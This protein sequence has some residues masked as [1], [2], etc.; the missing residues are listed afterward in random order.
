MSGWPYKVALITGA[1]SGLGEGIALA[2][3]RA[4]VK[5]GLLARRLDKLKDLVAKIETFGGQAIAIKCDVTISTEVK[6]A[7]STLVAAFG[8]VDLLIANAG[9][10]KVM[11]ADRFDLKDFEQT[12]QVNLFGAI[13]AVHAV[14]P[15]MIKNRRGHIVAIS[16]LASFRGYPK[17]FA[18]GGS[19]SAL[20]REMESLRNRVYARGI[21]VT[22]ICPGFIRT[23]LTSQLAVNQPFLMELEPAVQKILLAIRRNHRLYL[24]PFPASF[25]ARF[26]VFLPER[27]FDTLVRRLRGML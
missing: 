20:N 17:F 25:L 11:K 10:A 3:A 18:Y 23:E 4:G 21:K 19:K 9:I 8:S 22:T 7:H 14:L 6:A 24:F 26:M 13:Y 27:L 12:Y 2:L 1:S 15:D 16:S 5:V